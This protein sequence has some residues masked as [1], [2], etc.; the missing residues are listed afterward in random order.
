MDLTLTLKRET[1]NKKARGKPGKI[2]NS[3]YVST[4]HTV[5]KGGNEVLVLG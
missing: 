5:N 1:E 4:L 3:T 2:N